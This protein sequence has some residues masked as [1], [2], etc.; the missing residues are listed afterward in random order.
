LAK[1]GFTDSARLDSSGGSVRW[2]EINSK[3]AATVLWR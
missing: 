1:G 2:R 3:W